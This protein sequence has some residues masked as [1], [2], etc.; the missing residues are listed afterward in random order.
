M[1]TLICTKCKATLEMDDAFAGGVCRC[2]YCGTIQ[3]VPSHLKQ[4]SRGAVVG[5]N[6]GQKALYSTKAAT[7]AG[8][9]SS[10][11]DELANVVASSGLASGLAN[12]TATPR[13]DYATPATPKSSKTPLLIGVG[14]LVAVLLGVIGY[15][16]MSRSTAPAPAPAPVVTGPAPVPTPGQSGSERAK[17]P[18]FLDVPIDG[19]KVVYL[20]DRGQSSREVL[21]PLKAALYDSL[22]SLGA[23]REFQILFWTIPASEKPN[24]NEFA[25]PKGATAKANPDRIAECRKKFEDLT[26]SGRTDIGPVMVEAMKR[27]PQVIVIATAKGINLDDTVVTQVEKARGGK[28]VVI[29]TFDLTH[30]G[31]GASVLKAIAAKSGGTYKHIEP[32]ALRSR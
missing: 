10:G 14:A 8:L 25:Y 20:L 19:A 1:I 11:L 27:N 26:T 29:H 9:P 30:S 16:L 21:D 2:Q 5:S 3:T 22:E 7:G 32:G 4:S 24:V 13:V 23:D 17:G 28:P 6:S 12:R 18:Q 31:D 15:L